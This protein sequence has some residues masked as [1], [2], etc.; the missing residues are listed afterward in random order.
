MSQYERVVGLDKFDARL[1]VL[2]AREDAIKENDNERVS[3]YDEW[4]SK[5]K[6]SYIEHIKHNVNKAYNEAS[7]YADFKQ[8]LDANGI[9]YDDSKKHNT[10][11]L[12]ED[13]YHKY[14]DEPYTSKAHK[15]GRNISKDGEF[16]K[17]NLVA[18][19]NEMNKTLQKTVKAQPKQVQEQQEPQS[20][21]KGLDWS[22]FND[23]KYEKASIRTA[24]DAVVA[25]QKSE[26]DSRL[27]KLK[28]ELDMQMHPEKYQNKGKQPEAE[29]TEEVIDDEV[30][31]PEVIQVVLPVQEEPEEEIIED[32]DDEEEEFEDEALAA[33]QGFGVQVEKQ[34]EAISEAKELSILEKM[35]AKIASVRQKG[36][37]IADADYDDDEYD[38]PK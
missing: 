6:Y 12:R 24:A 28:E 7:S 36:E 32:D 26:I 19:F 20:S 2:A 21:Y 23:I 22:S 30:A 9:T 13:E 25:S 14:T 11:T 3:N 10:F 35:R 37:A 34:E 17:E 33:A 38:V 29:P 1:A 5:N 8:K 31:E 4:L 16:T 18:H 27:E 15:R